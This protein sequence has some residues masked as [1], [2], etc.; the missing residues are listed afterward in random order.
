VLRRIVITAWSI[1]RAGKGGL[2]M[3]YIYF[4]RKWKDN[5]YIIIRYGEKKKNSH[6][7]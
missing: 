6:N 2:D 3:P 1:K 7:Q 4:W 5:F